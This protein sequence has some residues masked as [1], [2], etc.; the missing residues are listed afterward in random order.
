MAAAAALALAVVAVAV[1]LAAAAVAGLERE[2]GSAVMAA[3]AH[4]AA[5][6]AR[7]VEKKGH[8]ASEFELRVQ[9][10]EWEQA[11]MCISH[12]D[13]ATEGAPMLMARPK[14]APPV[15]AQFVHLFH[16]A[17]M[18]KELGMLEHNIMH[19]RAGLPSIPCNG[20]GKADR[21]AGKKK[22]KKRLPA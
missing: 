10:E 11:R 7:K 8:S 14:D 15:E 19:N 3:R 5:A 18:P 22:K 17:L 21:K 4:G 9:P 16:R 6:Q 13:A 12:I 20:L 1:G 2:A